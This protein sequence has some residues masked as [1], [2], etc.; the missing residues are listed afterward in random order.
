VASVRRRSGPSRILEDVSS[1][2]STL[3]VDKRKQLAA[4]LGLFA[5]LFVAVG[6]VAATG[7][8][9]A[10][11][12]TFIVVALVVALL[13]AVM[14]WG[15]VHS[16]RLDTAENTL[17]AAIE[18]AVAASPNGFGQLC[19][20]GHQH[21]PTELHITDADVPDQAGTHQT[22]GAHQHT[23]ACAHDGSGA[24]CAHDCDTCV[25][26]SLRSVP[27]DDD[28]RPSPTRTREQRLTS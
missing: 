27:T 19:D 28:L 22:A 12:R 20:C 10:I 21:D 18:Q 23:A 2:L 13:L 8:G 6:A 15:V 24:A 4:T 1:P 17:D 11:I 14:A 9:T 3:P 16:V 26:S 25:L 7:P 5:V